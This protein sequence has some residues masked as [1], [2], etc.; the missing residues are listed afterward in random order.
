MEENVKN[1]VEPKEVNN[2]INKES[3]S[4]SEL[5]NKE[6]VHETK[7]SRC[8]M[9]CGFF[10]T[11]GFLIP[12]VIVVVLVALVL[13]FS[14]LK[15][16][17]INGGDNSNADKVKLDFYVM[18]QCPYGKQ[19]EDAIAPVLEKL[20]N[21]VEFTLDFIASEGSPGQF[22]SLHGTPEVLGDIAQLCAIK[23]N[24]DIYMK[25]ITCMNENAQAIP[26]NWKSCAEK[27][28]MNVAKLEECYSGEE[29]KALLSASAK[30]SEEAKAGGSPTIYLNNAPYSGGRGELDFMRA[31]CNEFTGDKPAACADIPE[32]KA[33]VLSVLSDKRCQECTA[34][35]S[36]LV[37]QLKS[38]FPG[39]KVNALDYSSEEGKELYASADL[40]ALPAFLFGSD[41]K[42]GEGYSMVQ[43]YLVESGEY[44]SLQ[45]G[46]NFDPT[47]EI[48]DNEIDDT[49]NGKVDC[50]DDD[51]K[52]AFVCREEKKN[53]LLLFIMSDFPYGKLGVEALKGVVDN[54]GEALT[55]DVHY[56]ASENADGTF[57]SLHGPYEADEN[58]VQLCVKKHSP[59]QWLDYLYCRSTKGI[60]GKDWKECANEVKADVDKVKA[61]FEGAEGKKLLSEDIKIANSL[62]IGGSRTWIANNKYQFGGIDAETVK[63][64]LCKYNDLEGCDKVL[65]TSTG[66]SNVPAGSCGG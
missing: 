59:E 9:D 66:A 64:E 44:Q 1:N 39:L 52:E 60:K 53:N 36:G 57:D 25:M 26:G 31:I 41:V 48:C 15:A 42:D 22:Q 56:I 2:E 16:P 58:I 10:K 32:P 63:G 18:S 34:A 13:L 33:V 4:K 8:S 27:T 11:K 19:V 37:G 50:D 21:N 40:K 20:G 17:G 7:P 28:G 3:A 45:I 47:K 30:K 24:P 54:F 61:C 23:H 43:R 62:G 55:Y 29:G 51:C 65:A 46:A 38:I 6:T 35:V 12:L 14:W 49:G 5:S